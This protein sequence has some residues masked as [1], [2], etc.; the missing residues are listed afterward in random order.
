MNPADREALVLEG[1][2][3]PDRIEWTVVVET[4]GPHDL[5]FRY[6]LGRG[7]RALELTDADR[8]GFWE[9]AG[10]HNEGDPWKEERYQARRNVMVESFT[11]ALWYGGEPV[12]SAW[13]RWSGQ[14]G[15]E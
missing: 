8:P 14:D 5:V 12:D 1:L 9:K 13:R 15:G 10:Y 11:H 6:A 4:T 3:H 2:V 7:E